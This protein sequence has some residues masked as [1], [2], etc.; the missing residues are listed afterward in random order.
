MYKVKKAIILAAGKGE[1]LWP[2]TRNIPKPLVKVNG[3]CMIET[4]ICALHKNNLYEIYIVVGFL[5]EQ[6][7]VLEKKYAGIT[8]IENP[9]FESCNNISSLYVAREH[10]PNSII[11]DGDQI[12]Y[13]NS[14]L[15]TEFERS[16]YHVVWTDEHTNEWL[17]KVKDDI[18][19]SCN[20][21]GGE[22]GWQLYSISRWN[23]EDGERLQRHIQIQFEQK[24]NT[25]IYW[26]DVPLFCYPEEYKLGIKKMRKSD[27]IE[28]DS[29]DELIRVDS[30][31]KFFKEKV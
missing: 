6:F 31:Y 12:I 18:V 20:R 10:I 23:E 28:I 3:K 11:M 8:L 2:V 5:K 16:G 29:L 1:R 24:Q 22:K 25:H 13:N 26:D 27:V 9:Y 30:S 15:S 7:K 21:T 14:I 4:A 17:L 19:C